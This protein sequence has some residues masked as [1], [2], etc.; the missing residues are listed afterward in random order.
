MAAYDDMLAIR[1]RW[2][3]YAHDLYG[4]GA[5][6]FTVLN[7]QDLVNYHFLFQARRQSILFAKPGG[8]FSRW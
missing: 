7:G 5:H 4:C 2:R 1:R 8:R 3:Q 6:I